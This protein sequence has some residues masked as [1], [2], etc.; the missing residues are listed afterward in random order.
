[1]RLKV[2]KIFLVYKLSLRDSIFIIFQLQNSI[3]KPKMKSDTEEEKKKDDEEKTQKKS[4][5]PR[6]RRTSGR[7]S[8]RPRDLVCVSPKSSEPQVA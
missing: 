8:P 3:Y 5:P 2:F 7:A 6:P 1:M 4:D